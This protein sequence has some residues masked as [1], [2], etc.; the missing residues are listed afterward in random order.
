MGRSDVRLKFARPP[1]LVRN[2]ARG[3]LAARQRVLP[4]GTT[5]PRLEGE[6]SEVRIDP[7]HLA[8]YRAVCGFPSDG[9]LPVTYPH[10][11][12]I[13]L[14]VAL[15]AQ[16]AFG[17]RLLG[18]I[19][20]ANE[21][22]W[23]RPLSEWETYGVRCWI[24]GHRE[25]DRG[26][27]FDLHTELLD[28]DGPAWLERCTV[29]AR[30]IA[31]GAQTARA[32]R[33]ALR[34][35]KPPADAAVAEVP[36]AASHRQARAY[37][38]ISGD[39]NPIHMTDFTAR[40]FGFDKA[41]AHGMWTKACSLAALGPELTSAPCRIPVDFKLPVFL[42]TEVRLRH[43]HAA[44]AWTFVLQDASKGRPHLAGSVERL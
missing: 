7:R 39:V 4:A 35:P 17:L 6:V 10:V 14:Q 15:M 11:L 29:L 33:A 44:H 32:A 12:A 3:V 28:R 40:W 16:P 30:K 23:L 9:Q 5:I 18:L 1:A 37:A 8:R 34:V 41:V 26:Q 13:S 22:T 24:E 19:H 27:E 43:W 31:G 21:I 38:W 36:F 42:P 20:I 2:Y 25:T